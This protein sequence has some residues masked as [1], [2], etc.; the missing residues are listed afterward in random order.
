MLQRIQ[1]AFLDMVDIRKRVFAEMA[2]LQFVVHQQLYVLVHVLLYMSA[3][4]PPCRF[5]FV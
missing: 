4:L 1:Y 2:E 5:V 3:C